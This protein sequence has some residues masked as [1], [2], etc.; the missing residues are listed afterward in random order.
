MGQTRDPWQIDRKI[1]VAIL[2]G[3]LAQGAGIVWWASSAEAR[4]G[5][6]EARVDNHVRETRD[7][8]ARIV[9]LEATGPEVARRLGRIEDKLDRL[10][11]H[12]GASK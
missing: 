9:R 11:E 10:L 8:P 1:S 5:Q 12:G 6:I 3:L 4:L 7:D 2:V